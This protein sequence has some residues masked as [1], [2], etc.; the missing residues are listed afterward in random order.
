MIYIC[1]QI[2]SIEN[3]WQLEFSNKFETSSV[4]EKSFFIK[5]AFTEEDLLMLDLDQFDSI[6]E[7]ISYFVQIPKSLKVIAL[8][9]EPKLAH[10][11]YMIKKGFKSYL[12]KKTN[13]LIIEQ[14]IKTVFAGNVWIYPELMS[15]IIKH[16]S[17]NSEQTNS[18]NLLSEL[19]AKESEVAYEVSSGLSNK[20]IA[21]KLNVQVVTIK[22]HIGNIFTKLN[23]KDRVTL[24]ILINK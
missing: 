18:T 19:T 13:K 14:S 7:I 10:G 6:D 21:N 17:I 5:N 16:I 11:T 2:L 8:I 15:F 4:N 1:T 12:G 22:K 24:A 3:Y 20:E 9:N 23:I